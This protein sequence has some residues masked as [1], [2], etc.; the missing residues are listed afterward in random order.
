MQ[1]ISIEE[2]N[3]KKRKEKKR[4]TL[5]YLVFDFPVVHFS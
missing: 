4:K 2:M 1:N 3:Q 5:T